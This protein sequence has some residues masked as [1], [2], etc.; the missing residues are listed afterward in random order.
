MSV[1]IFDARR[2]KYCFHWIFFG[3]WLLTLAQQLH[4][5]F[6]GRMPFSL[7]SNSLTFYLFIIFE[8]S[9]RIEKKN[10]VKIKKKKLEVVP[11]GHSL[12]T[13]KLTQKLST[14]SVQRFLS[15]LKNYKHNFCF[16]HTFIGQD[17]YFERW[18]YKSVDLNENLF[19]SVQRLQ[20]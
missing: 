9:I 19:Y 12:D 8:I 11:G 2:V 13:I 6:W 3:A 16:I 18:A 10:S 1:K 14:Q 17:P 20:L 7:I 5:Q 4:F 15:P